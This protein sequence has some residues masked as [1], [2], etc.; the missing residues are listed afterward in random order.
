MTS[1]RFLQVLLLL[2]LVVPSAGA[3]EEQQS[4]AIKTGTISGRVVNEKGQPMPDA[5]VSIRAYSSTGMARST[6]T[7][8][9]GA[10]QFS[11][12]SP[13]VYLLT[14][15]FPAYTMAPRDPD[16]TQSTSYRVGDNVTLVLIKGGVI[17]GRVSTVSGEPVIGVRVRAQLIRDG[18]GRTIRYGATLQERT[19]DDRGIYRFYGLPSG[20]F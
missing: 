5:G 12:M 6:T 18:R 10:F 13:L 8:S 7:D 9:E 14:A 3:Q 11:G 2:L 19:T 20:S 15:G 1:L 4:R 17:T 16:S